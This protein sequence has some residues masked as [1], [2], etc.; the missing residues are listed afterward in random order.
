MEHQIKNS[1]TM[2]KQVKVT[3]KE[4]R[5]SGNE[6]LV[7]AVEKLADHCECFVNPEHLQKKKT[8]GEK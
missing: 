4:L 3:A 1:K 5:E 8:K 6:I 7:K 2:P